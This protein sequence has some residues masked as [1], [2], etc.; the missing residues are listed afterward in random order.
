MTKITTNDERKTNKGSLFCEPGRLRRPRSLPF[1]AKPQ[2]EIPH[3]RRCCGDCVKVLSRSRS[4]T[5]SC[6]LAFWIGVGLLPGGHDGGLPRSADVIREGEASFPS[7]AGWA[8]QTIGPLALGGV[9][10]SPVF[11]A[12]QAGLGKRSGLW[13]LH[14]NQQHRFPARCARWAGQ[15]TGPLGR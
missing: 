7:P 6:K 8:R 10:C 14:A 5:R 2:N 11:P 4:L 13:P 1:C 12:L 15:I 9:S 3:A